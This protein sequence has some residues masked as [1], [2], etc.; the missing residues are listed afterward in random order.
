MRGFAFSGAYIKSSCLLEVSAG[1]V[2]GHKAKHGFIPCILVTEPVAPN[3]VGAIQ[4]AKTLSDSLQC[5]LKEIVCRRAG[6]GQVVRVKKYTYL[7]ANKQSWP[8]HFT[9]S[10]KEQYTGRN[11]W[12]LTHRAYPRG[13]FAS[14]SFLSVFP[15]QYC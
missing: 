4:R 3:L 13:S 2:V 11:S 9:M 14:I 1:L 10:V 15:R 5:F 7:S 8:V 6:G 12:T